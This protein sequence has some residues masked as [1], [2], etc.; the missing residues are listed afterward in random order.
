ML[1]ITTVLLQDSDNAQVSILSGL[2]WGVMAGQLV[3]LLFAVLICSVLFCCVL[4]C[5]VMNW[6]IS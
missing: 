3:R 5:S 2:R 1:C 6:P 4:L